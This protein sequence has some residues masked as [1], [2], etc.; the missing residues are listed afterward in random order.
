VCGLRLCKLCIYVQ[1]R[2]TLRSGYLRVASPLKLH[3]NTNIT[4][5]FPLL[6]SIK[7]PVFCIDSSEHA[8]QIASHHFLRW[9]LVEA[10]RSAAL[11]RLCFGA[12]VAM[13][14]KRLNTANAVMLILLG[15]ALLSCITLLQDHQSPLI[16]E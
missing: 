3:G 5:M 12:C 11:Q 7:P 4:K 14:T 9:R 8:V 10:V 13:K 15:R 6:C 2:R 1:K 16:Q